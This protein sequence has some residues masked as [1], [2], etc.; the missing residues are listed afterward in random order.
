MPQQSLSLRRAIEYFEERQ[1]IWPYEEALL[2]PVLAILCTWFD[3]P[4]VVNKRSL[5]H[6]IEESMVALYY[7]DRWRRTTNPEH[8]IVMDVCGGKGIFSLLLQHY[9]RQHWPNQQLRDII[10]LEKA[11][12][13]QIEWGHLTMLSDPPVTILEDC[14]LHD[15]DELID[16]LAVFSSPLALSGI[17]LCKTLTPSLITLA[18]RLGKD[19]CPYVSVAPCC[20]PRVVLSK[21]MADDERILPIG[22]Y[23]SDHHRKLRMKQELFRRS[24]R[25]NVNIG[26]FR[27]QEPGHVLSDCPLMDS[28]TTHQHAVENW[29]P[30]WQCG[31]VGHLR[32]SCPGK[33][34][35]V[36]A[37]VREAETVSVAGVLDSSHPLSTYCTRLLPAFQDRSMQVIETG[38]ENRGHGE[39]NWYSQRKSLF[40]VPLFC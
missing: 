37:V 39:T 28:T 20:L 16:M 14:N 10:L 13:K 25:R 17:H 5:R 22:R 33:H 4:S 8:F 9:A 6:E 36:P 32:E 1:P 38:L 7:L 30:C 26:C 12:S 11:T 35:S 40:I 29:T 18:N 15:T 27:C 21:H 31:E 23:E 34:A 3:L 2:Q 19:R 24:R